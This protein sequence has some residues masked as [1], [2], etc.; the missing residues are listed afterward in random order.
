MANPEQPGRADQDQAPPAHAGPT[1]SP[2]GEGRPG[3]AHRTRS[4]RVT[5]VALLLVPLLALVGLWAFL[6]SLTL[7]TALQEHHGNQVTL[8]V[9][10]AARVAL[11][12]VD[13]ERQATF[14]WQSSPLHPPVG[15]L[16]ASRRADDAAIAFYERSSAAVPGQQAVIAELGKIPGIRSAVGSGALSAPAAFQAYS[17][18]V[19]GLFN[20]YLINPE[21]DT[22]LYQ[23]TLAAIDLGWALEELSRE[24]TL[25]AGAEVDRGQM[26]PAVGVLFARAAGAQSLL[27][28]SAIAQFS[29]QLQASLQR[30]Y[31]SQLHAQLVALEDR[32]AG[33]ARGQALSPATLKAWGPVSQ[34]FLGQLL[35][36]TVASEGP[37]AAL[38]GQ[39]SNRLFLEAGL[40]GGL[41]LLAVVVAV[42]LSVRFS[43]GIRRELTGLHDSAAQMANERLPRVVARLREGDEVDVAAESPPLAVG[44][45]TEIA[46]V[47]DA[48]STV[49]RTAVDAA[50]GQA[51]LRKGVNQVFL[52]LS[53][54][55]Q[56][57]LHRQLGMLDTMERGTDDPA[58][59]ADLF[60]LD[61]SPP[62][63][64]ATP[65]A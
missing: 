22:S 46:R 34:E 17:A 4:I 37:L 62:G 30:L 6:A 41:G 15:Q 56:S 1:A 42:F 35:A 64:A 25:V 12:A 52:N 50:V 60:R 8:Q 23:H 13:A 53:L 31:T 26:I 45:I 59:L 5:L 32:I 40:A 38:Q 33:T 36:G 2:P 49:Q 43:R 20:G 65:K 61:P 9:S 39:T 27:A 51:N 47:A 19:D 3:R 14:L 28:A 21:Y 58:V 48:F 57:L 7:G 29:G 44:T 10:Q 11:N 24:A 54:R 18:V 55:N 16:T 63:C